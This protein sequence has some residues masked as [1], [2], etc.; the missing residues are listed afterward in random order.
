MTSGYGNECEH[1]ASEH[2]G[3]RCGRCG[4]DIV[5]LAN[6]AEIAR[7]RGQLERL[8][9]VADKAIQH[10]TKT[11]TDGA[12]RIAYEAVA[13]RYLDELLAEIVETGSKAGG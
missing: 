2:E 4:A 3:R 5:D 7:L 12:S 13:Y 11:L 6:A 8:R 10:R 9:G 1:P